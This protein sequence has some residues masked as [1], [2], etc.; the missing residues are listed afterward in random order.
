MTLTGCG[1][2]GPQVPLPESRVD[3]PPVP[4]DLKLCFERKVGVPP[5]G[6]MSKRDLFALIDKLKTSADG[7]DD[8]GVRL[9]CWYEDIARGFLP[10]TERGGPHGACAVLPVK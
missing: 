7:K 6:K 8:C 5:K 4:A 9:T 3:L 10:A 2:F 1:S